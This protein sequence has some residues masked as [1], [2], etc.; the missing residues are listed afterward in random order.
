MAAFTQ[1]FFT[2]TRVG[3]IDYVS[4]LMCIQ[5]ADQAAMTLY[6]IVKDLE[7]AI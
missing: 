5:K 4:L 1:G 2:A 6:T 3:T 7:A